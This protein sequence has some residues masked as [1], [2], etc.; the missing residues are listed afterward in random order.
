MKKTSWTY[1]RFHSSKVIN[2]AVNNTHIVLIAKKE[3]CESPTDYRPIS[4]TTTVYKLIGKVM[5]ERL[6][7][8]LPNTISE[9]QMAFVK[10]RKITE[11]IL[12]ANEAKDFWRAKKTKGFV[13]KLD[14]EKAF[15]KI[16]WRFIDYIL[17]KK[18]Y[19]SDWRKMIANCISSV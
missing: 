5:T 14:I 9:F 13:I 7:P 15:D 6:K 19:S 11:A 17:M 12:I 2:K 3:K 18:N 10:G 4:L 1:S 8:I 16:S